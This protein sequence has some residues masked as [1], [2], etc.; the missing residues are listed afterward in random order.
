MSGSAREAPRARTAPRRRAA[1][2]AAAAAA[3]RSS[4]LAERRC[5]GKASLP[6]ER[7]TDRPDSLPLSLSR[8]LLDIFFSN[9]SFRKP[10]AA[11]G[12]AWRYLLAGL[13]ARAAVPL[14]TAQAAAA[15]RCQQASSEGRLTEGR[16]Y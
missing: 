8:P 16:R 15:A 11:P 4:R 10:M 14:P 7:C 5:A 13:L 6:A 12:G 9:S 2:A 1:A 3:H